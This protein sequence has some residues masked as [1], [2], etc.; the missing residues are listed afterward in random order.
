MIRTLAMKIVNRN[1]LGSTDGGETARNDSSR[2]RHEAQPSERRRNR[3]SADARGAQRVTADS[4]DGL[5]HG[6]RTAR[7][8]G[9]AR[10]ATRAVDASRLRRIRARDDE[11][12]FHLD[13]RV[14]N[15]FAGHW[16]VAAH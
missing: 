13:E 9:V 3:A 11:R 10:D 2:A 5:F 16:T 14:V 15:D 6:D 8:R 12:S 1:G 7:P 4:R